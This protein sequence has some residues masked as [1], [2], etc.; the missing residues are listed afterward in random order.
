MFIDIHYYNI[1][2][3]FWKNSFW[4]TWERNAIFWKYVIEIVCLASQ[5]L[6]IAIVSCWCRLP[7]LLTLKWS[8]FLWRVTNKLPPTLKK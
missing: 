1:F 8:S 3:W 7:F 4:R 5:F 6:V 2:I